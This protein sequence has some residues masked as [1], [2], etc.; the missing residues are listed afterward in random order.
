M[1][2]SEADRFARLLL[3]PFLVCIFPV[4]IVEAY[5]PAERERHRTPCSSESEVALDGPAFSRRN[6]VALAI[7]PRRLS[8]CGLPYDRIEGVVERPLRGVVCFRRAP[9]FRED[10][11]QGIE[12]YLRAPIEPN[13]GEAQGDRFYTAVSRQREFSVILLPFEAKPL[14]PLRGWHQE[15]PS[16]SGVDPGSLNIRERHPGPQPLDR[17][18]RAAIRRTWRWNGR[19]FIGADQKRRHKYERQESLHARNPTPTRPPRQPLFTAPLQ[20]VA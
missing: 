5:S 7:T 8:K 9:S 18:E 10:L 19:A 6:Y 15:I 2:R 3:L 11:H 12:L 16:H 14:P 1:R 4:E 20:M 13:R 17:V